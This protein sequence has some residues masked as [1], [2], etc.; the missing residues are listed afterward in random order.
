[1]TSKIMMGFAGLVLAA[2]HGGDLMAQTQ[3]DPRFIGGGAADTTIVRTVGNQD[4]GGQKT[5][6]VNPIIRNGSPTMFFADT[7]NRSAMV[8]VNGNI[9]YVLRGCGNADTNWCTHNGVWPLVINLENNDVTIGG[10]ARARAYLH[11]SDLRSKQNIEPLAAAE[12]MEKVSRI[13]AVSYD[14]KETGSPS[15]GFI[16]QDL[17][18]IYPSMVQA[19]DKGMLSVEYTQLIAPMLVVIQELR[20]ELDAEKERYEALEARIDLIEAAS[21]KE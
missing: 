6:T 1:M 4:I 12:T 19:D 11:T 5:F 9:F 10:N 2:S 13:R 7:D 3:V 14:W 15:M 20:S 16:A 18:E 17:Q 8:H 21:I